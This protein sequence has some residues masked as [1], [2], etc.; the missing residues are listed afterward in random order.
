[1]TKEKLKELLNKM[2]LT[3]KIYQLIQIASNFYTEDGMKL[4][5]PIEELGINE[6]ILWNSGSVINAKGAKSVKEIQD[7]YLSKNKHKIP[8]LF[9]ADVINGYKTIFPIP[10]AQG[11]SFDEKAVYDIAKAS[12]KEATTSGCHVTFSPMVDLC[13]DS[14]WGRVMESAGG[15]DPY[16]GSIMAKATV[17]GYQGNNI[18]DKN[19]IA[20]CVKHFAAYGAGVAGREYN[21]VD[22]SRREL[23]QN[24]LPPYKAAID[25]KASMMM[26]SFNIIDGIPATANTW[27]MKDLLRNKWKFDGVLISDYSAIKEIFVH[28]NAKDEKEAAKKALNATCDIDMMTNLYTNNLYSLVKEGSIKESQVDDA[29]MRI[30]TLKNDLG[31]FENPYKDASEIEEQLNHL[32][33]ENLELSKEASGKTFVLLKNNNILPLDKNKK[34]AL[35]GPHVNNK[36]IVGN[37]SIFADKNSVKSL[38]EAFLENYNEEYLKIFEGCNM[39]ASFE[40]DPIFTSIGQSPLIID[41]EELVNELLIKEACEGAMDADVIVLAIGEHQRQTGEACSRTNLEIPYYQQKLLIALKALNKPIVT[42]LYNG[43]PLAIKDVLDSSDA[44]LEVWYPGTNGNSAVV[45]TLFGKINP[46]GKLNMSFPYN[47]GQCPIYYNHYQT[48]RPHI[49]DE[50]YVSRY[51]DAPTNPLLPFGFGLSY[52]NFIYNSIK[53]DNNILTKNN[54]LNVTVSITNDSKYN[55]YEVVQLYI[56]DVYGSI[57]RPVKELKGFKK[58]FFNANETK[59]VSFI[60]NT[61]MLEFYDNNCKKIIENGLFKVYI[62]TNSRDVLETE[63]EV[64]YLN[65]K[66]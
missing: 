62:G 48:G 13:R 32:S 38:K 56:Q 21:S 51:I 34:I 66:N 20:S 15:E 27:L 28:G 63:F 65:N 29:V 18:K 31:L 14:R 24:Y 57:V 39:L 35:I 12:A 6:E 30:L 42:L 9:M 41:N 58:V 43:R 52:S 60:L 2:S 26:T 8:L 23:F 53:L 40:Y 61:K 37:W 59:E 16:L 36:N 49:K 64:I 3:D 7:K 17:E 44:V 11:C 50:R 45:D 1:M 54:K 55:G 22:M 25:A 10:I 46:S 33:K 5:G 47:A 4:T 19:S